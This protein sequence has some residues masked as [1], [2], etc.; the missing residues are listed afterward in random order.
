MA[1]KL[2]HFQH[3]LSEIDW[4]V[5]SVQSEM[6]LGVKPEKIAIIAP[7][8]KFLE[9][10]SKF[11][12][13]NSIPVSYVRENSVLEEP[14][15]VA[16]LNMVKLSHF[17]VQDTEQAEIYWHKVLSDPCW[18]ISS[19]TIWKISLLSFYSRNSWS[20]VFKL[21]ELDTLNL[22]QL[23][24]DKRHLY[25]SEEEK[26]QVLSVYK[27]FTEISKLSL[28][29]SAERILN[30][31]LGVEDTLLGSEDETEQDAEGEDLDSI[32]F[33][34]GENIIST[35]DS[36]FL[37]DFS[38]QETT[39]STSDNLHHN[40]VSPFKDYYFD[41]ARKSGKTDYLAFLASLRVLI[42]QLR[43]MNSSNQ[44]LVADWLNS[45]EV[46]H[47][48]GRRLTSKLSIGDSELAVNLLTAHS[49]KGLEF[50]SVYLIHCNKEVWDTKGR[51]SILSLPK[52]L[53]L[54]R[55]VENVDDR[56]RLFFVAITRAEKNLYLSYADQNETKSLS[57]LAFIDELSLQ[58][59]TPFGPNILELNKLHYNL[60]NSSHSLLQISENDFLAPELIGYQLSVTHLNNFLDVERGGPV[61]FLESNLLRF[62][63]AKSLATTFGTLMHESMA[64]FYKEFAVTK[65]LPEL[66]Y[67]NSLFKMLLSRQRLSI[68]EKEN[69]L[70]RGLE[71]LQVY[72][73]NRKDTFSFKDK[74]EFNFKDQ[75]VIIGQARLSGKI[76]K[77]VLE[78]E[79]GQKK[80]V[81]VDLKTGKSIE[82]WT[83]Q[84]K[85]DGSKAEPKNASK[86]DNYRRQ[87]VFYKILVENSREFKGKYTVDKGQLDFLEFTKN[88][89][90]NESLET[91]ISKSE[92]EELKLLIQKV[93]TRIMNKNF[94]LPS[95]NYNSGLAGKKQFISDLLSE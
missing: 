85:S 74:I 86:A 35:E 29:D 75:G 57:K 6:N 28:H 49:A 66:E 87:L 22:N 83:D 48:S 33:S 82:K 18:K 70:V 68:S 3:Q 62:P 52:N 81:V 56:L 7:K 4:L 2:L 12:L 58:E 27:Y 37:S 38:G 71:H 24:A 15:I 23:S 13:K 47:R 30:K 44:I 31:L 93:W 54:Q 36:I 64:N 94:T 92:S 78:E 76:D 84:G 16:L 39:S 42:D 69:L 17:I 26:K 43:K 90:H 55:E 14:P 73:E 80:I 5:K 9:N 10:I 1:V 65:F 61:R 67:L 95:D 11:F 91:S 60:E 63:S 53:G 50:E 46:L 19:E 21:I 32:N 59:E 34:S 51:N 72:Y 20:E 79:D 77:M 88:T 25:L 40:F 45:L 41:Q 89:K 8:H